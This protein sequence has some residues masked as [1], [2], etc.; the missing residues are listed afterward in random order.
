MTMLWWNIGGILL[1][2]LFC[3]AWSRT[4]LKPKSLLS[5]EKFDI[6]RLDPYPDTKIKGKTKYRITMAMKALDQC[7]WLTVD[8]NYKE[9]HKIRT[10]FL[11]KYRT[12]IVQC[13]PQA[14]EACEEALHTIT[15]FLC[16]RYP[17]L[18]EI[19]SSIVGSM[20]KN[21]ETG[22]TFPVGSFSKGLSP[23]EIASRLTMEDLT[24]LLKNE[25]GKHYM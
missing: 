16:N 21:K 13:L 19:E 20:V 10:E 6:N 18:F 25:E 4:Q 15:A 3:M 14:E 2:L 7:N 24:I 12:M 9:Q 23:L 8:K 11:D 17:D 22:E 5:K 1:V